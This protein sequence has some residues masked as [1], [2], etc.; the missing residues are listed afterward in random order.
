MTALESL[1]SLLGY[2]V[3]HLVLIYESVTFSA[4][5]VRWLTLH[6]R[7]LNSLTNAERRFTA[8][9]LDT[10]SE[11]YVTTDGQSASLSW[12]KAL[13]WGLLPDL[14]FCQTV[15]GLLLWG[16]LSDE[17]AGLTFTIV[18]GPRQRSHSRV[19]VPLDSR[20]SFTVSHSRHPIS[21]PSTTRRVTVEVF[22]A[23]STEETLSN[24]L[25]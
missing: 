9:T 16:V 20:L 12:N 23:A 8:H 1:H 7:T 4:S 6:I 13:I 3:T 21:S 11:S 22:D 10:E 24:Q 19:R 5:V 2:T 17:R 25:N 18:A 15:A 14:Y